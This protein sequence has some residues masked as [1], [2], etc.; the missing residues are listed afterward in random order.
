MH[1]V[2]FRGKLKHENNEAEVNCSAS[3]CDI[4]VFSLF[5]NDF[6]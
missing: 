5:T 6:R 1:I 4:L 3:V 2:D